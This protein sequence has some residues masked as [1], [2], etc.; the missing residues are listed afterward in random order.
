MRQNL[1]LPMA[2]ESAAAGR[3]DKESQILQRIREW[4]LQGYTLSESMKRG[5]PKCPSRAI[6]MITAGEQIDQLPLA[7]NA[8]ETDINTK[9]SERTK[10]KPVHPIYPVIVISFT[11]F[12]LLSMMT[13]VFPQFKAVL[14]EMV[15]ESELPAVTRLLI[16]IVHFGREYWL[17]IWV[18]FTLT[19]LF[20][21]PAS[22][23]L[24]FRLR[25]PEK[26]YL[27][28]RIGDFFKWHLPILHWFER[29]YSMVQVIEYLRL[30]LNSGFTINKSI[31]N[32][33][34]LDVN[35]CFKKRLKKWLEKVERGDNVA[36]AIRKS[37]L[38][39]ALAW[40][41]DEQ[42]NQGNTPAVLETLES[43][44]RSNY[45]YGVNLARFIIWPCI[46]LTMGIIVGFV[47]LGI[48]SPSIAVI[49][50]LTGLVTP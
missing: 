21:I 43:W 10:I 46:I 34:A 23:Y 45:S 35:N 6:A 2:L 50:H 9:T 25:R 4:L 28:S 48:F 22:I 1:P 41:F 5:Y 38:G 17:L 40:A 39:S 44:Y 14:E 11:I 49:N 3:K 20:V 42:I 37:K 19:V 30:S 32:T 33:L 13:Y 24:K 15:G 18:V 27:T 36:D 8:I 47:V 7:I 16:E 26:P 29:N 31:D 12:I